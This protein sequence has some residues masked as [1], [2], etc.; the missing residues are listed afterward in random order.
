MAKDALSKLQSLAKKA[1]GPAAKK[2]DDRIGFSLTGQL[3]EALRKWVP[4]KL[5]HDKFKANV[6]RY[7]DELKQGVFDLWKKALLQNKGKPENPKLSVNNEDNKTDC[8]GMF[9]VSER[10]S[11]AV[12]EVP[13]G[14]EIE[15][16]FVD[17][18][19][20]M[21]DDPNWRPKAQK[22]VETELS[23]LP[24]VN[25]PLTELLAG[26][27]VGKTFV[28]ATEA[29][30]S[31]VSK[32]I[33]ILDGEEAG[34]INMVFTA[35]E[36]ESLAQGRNIKFQTQVKPGFLE[37]VYTYCDNENHLNTVMRMMNPILSLK[38]AKFAV[39]DSEEVRR[40]RFIAEAAEVFGEIDQEEDD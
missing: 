3:G 5:L 7:S 16:T 40:D 6:E 37:R 28:Q 10:Y 22:M 38:S 19:V 8:E 21:A 32:L 13:E 31:A 39:N 18:L 15:E 24:Q 14:K 4:A 30:K 25:L 2:K 33:E 35:A 26:K 27:K 29:Q 20:E 12:P 11:V 9:L 17:T 36:R 34:A 1:T 23:F